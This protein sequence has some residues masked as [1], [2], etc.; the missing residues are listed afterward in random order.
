MA[1]PTLADLQAYAQQHLNYDGQSRGS[2]ANSLATLY[3]AHG[4]TLPVN[5]RNGVDIPKVLANPN[6]QAMM[7][8]WAD[9]NQRR[10]LEANSDIVRHVQELLDVK[11][12]EYAANDKTPHDNIPGL[13]TI[14][15][16]SE[17]YQ[18]RGEAIP[19]RRGAAGQEFDWQASVQDTQNAAVAAGKPLPRSRVASTAEPEN[20]PKPV[21]TE[22]PA[23]TQKTATPVAADEPQ[24]PVELK[25]G[26]EALYRP[27]NANKASQTQA[28]VVATAPSGEAPA[29]ASPVVLPDVAPLK[30]NTQALDRLIGST[31]LE[32]VKNDLSKLV[33]VP[34]I[35]P[36]KQRTKLGKVLHN[37]AHA[38]DNAADATGQ[39]LATA[40]K[41]TGK[42]VAKGAVGAAKGV[43]IA[44]EA[45][46]D[47][48]EATGKFVGKGVAAGAKGVAKGVVVAAEGVADAA[49]ATGEFISDKTHGAPKKVVNALGDAGEA[50]G[51]AVGDA[52]KFVGK[53]VA[54]GAKGVAKGAVV[55]AEGNGVPKKVV[56]AV[57]DAGE[58]TGKFVA[59]GAVAGAKGVA[60]GAVVAAEGVA[61][62]AVAT[63][64][65]IDKKTN[66]APTKAFNAVVDTTNDLILDK[67]PKAKNAQE[68]EQEKPQQELLDGKGRNRNGL[69][70][71]ATGE[72]R[73]PLVQKLDKE[74]NPE[75]DKE[76][77]PVLVRY[78][79]VLQR[80]LKERKGLG[81]LLQDV[82]LR[83]AHLP[84][85]VVRGLT[86]MGELVVDVDGDGKNSPK[87]FGRDRG[88][89][90]GVQHQDEYRL[91]AEDNPLPDNIWK[92]AAKAIDLDKV[93]E[94][95]AKQKGDVTKGAVLPGKSKKGISLE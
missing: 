86:G 53:G 35:E 78:D 87:D 31:D 7:D 84:V 65:F 90:V 39:A 64:K 55:A 6:L 71:W 48:G 14:G 74:G 83:A 24:Q 37:T 36:P 4:M 28:P 52:G 56:N 81:K 68:S 12:G 9:P 42:F 29:P 57:G 61:D 91:C 72:K 10:A 58:A 49:V 69:V 76:G 94:E 75:L 47:A 18:Q 59:K 20:T 73:Y 5:S 22:T 88:Q 38:L 60:K 33:V 85:N 1:T 67:D 79:P 80:E 40:G 17:F 15:K 3:A 82:S 30:P 21:K 46:G 77:N 23:P 27:S 70:R 2:F 13:N 32:K 44:A 34:T 45:V 43:V 51:E 41:E 19:M 50:V 11:A 63:G 92:K 95:A 8:A 93:L 54:A 66:G 26:Q 16:L 62:A 89:V 25:K